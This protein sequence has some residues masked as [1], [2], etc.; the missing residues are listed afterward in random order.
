MFQRR[1]SLDRDVS[2]S[3]EVRDS[4]ENNRD[5]GT[6]RDQNHGNYNQSAMGYNQTNISNLSSY[7]SNSLAFNE[8]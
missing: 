7:G 4:R 6:N 8:R 5:Q 2:D 3:R 1:Q